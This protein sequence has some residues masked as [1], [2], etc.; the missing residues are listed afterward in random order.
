MRLRPAALPLP[1]D[2]S[3]SPGPPDLRLAW[4]DA[5]VERAA[6]RGA[7]VFGGPA[8]HPGHDV[9]RVGD[10]APTVVGGPERCC[11]DRGQLDPR[12]GRAAFVDE[13]PAAALARDE[14]VVGR[15]PEEPAAPAA[16][17]P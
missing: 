5:G 15:G 4:L 17:R 12:F 7:P 8:L 10:V 3:R 11:G 16:D 14:H 9:G 1:G 2:V 6:A 13:P